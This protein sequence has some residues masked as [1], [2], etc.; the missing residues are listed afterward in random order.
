[1]ELRKRGFIIGTT[2]N[3][4]GNEIAEAL[5]ELIST[6][7]HAAA[8]VAQDPDSVFDLLSRLSKVEGASLNLRG[9]VL[10]FIVGRLFSLKGYNI[11]IR[12]KV[13]A[14]NGQEAEIDVKARNPKEVVCVECKAK[15]PGKPVELEEVKE[16]VEEKLPRIKNWLGQFPSLPQ[17]K[18]FEFCISGNYTEEAEEYADNVARQHRKQPISFLTGREIVDELRD[19][20]QTSI[21]RIFDEQFTQ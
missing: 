19:Y 9:V 7:C 20:K 5:R 21:V 12:Q 13:R 4:F 14:S 15:A 18:R 6:L 3:L 8:A 17:Q 10:E 11:D 16:W 2:S 1:M